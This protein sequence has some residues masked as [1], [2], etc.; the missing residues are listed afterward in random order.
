MVLSFR[1]AVVLAV[2][3]LI[4]FLIVL[5][6][7]RDRR[8]SSHCDAT[9]ITTSGIAAASMMYVARHSQGRSKKAWMLLSAALVFNTLVE[10]SWAVIEIFLHQDPFPSVADICYLALYPLFA[11]GIFLLPAIPLS[12]RER[13]KKSFWMLQLSSYRQLWY[14][15]SSLSPLLLLPAR[16]LILACFSRQPIRLWI[17]FCSLP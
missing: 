15:G 12:L 6:Q 9:A 8:P 14:S 5:T 1:M 16:R 2:S 4:A 17:L 10:A 3:I 11:L 7:V 13:Q